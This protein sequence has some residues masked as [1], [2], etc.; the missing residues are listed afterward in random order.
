[1]AAFKIQVSLLYKE[2]IDWLELAG[3]FYNTIFV[4]NQSE[5]F[6]DHLQHRQKEDGKKKYSEF[7]I[8]GPLLNTNGIITIIKIKNP[9]CV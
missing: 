9:L 4:T 8:L 7:L 6:K 5:T 2:R 1:M 3:S